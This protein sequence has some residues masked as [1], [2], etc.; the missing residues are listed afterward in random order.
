MWAYTVQCTKA[1]QEIIASRRYLDRRSVESLFAFLGSDRSADQDDTGM[2]LATEARQEK[3]RIRACFCGNC[4]PDS[5]EALS[6]VL[7]T[8]VD[9]RPNFRRGDGAGCPGTPEGKHGDQQRVTYR[10]ESG[11]V[12]LSMFLR[13]DA[14]HG[15]AAPAIDYPV[16]RPAAYEL[17]VPGAHSMSLRTLIGGLSSMSRHDEIIKLSDPDEA[18]EIEGPAQRLRHAAMQIFDVTGRTSLEQVL[19]TP[20][21]LPGSQRA[22]LDRLAVQVAATWPGDGARVGYVM[23]SADVVERGGNQSLIR[24]CG[25]NWTRDLVVPHW[26]KVPARRDLDGEGPFLVVLRCY[27]HRHGRWYVAESY[28]HPILRRDVWMLVDANGERET[29]R[30]LYWIREELKEQGIRVRVVKPL[31][32]R[33]VEDICVRPDF[34]VEL[35]LR[36]GTSR[37]LVVETMGSKDRTYLRGKQG[38]HERMEQLGELV[39]DW[40]LAHMTREDHKREDWALRNKI[41]TWLSLHVGRPLR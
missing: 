36:D 8:K 4:D 28:A 19:L 37:L 1:G 39:L 31:F 21:W 24:Q 12:D 5:A 7:V 30:V 27:K 10:R 16:A 22:L 23:S 2:R 33:F 34:E 20:R 41:F 26:I 3:R 29:A 38:P 18:P 9:R 14:A 15:A 17:L 11:P 40:R 13:V 35:T 6:P 25:R 32:D